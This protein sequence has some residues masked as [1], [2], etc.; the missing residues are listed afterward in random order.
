MENKNKDTQISIKGLENLGNTCYLNTTLQCLLF[1]P[2]FR[3]KVLNYTHYDMCKTP[4]LTQLHDVYTKLWI[5]RKTVIPRG[6]THTISQSFIGKMIDVKNPNDLH[7]FLSLFVDALIEEN[8]NIKDD[9]F[10][11]E[12]SNKIYKPL[13]QKIL[14]GRQ[15]S[16]IICSHCGYQTVNKEIFSS[17]MLSFSPSSLTNNTFNKE[18]G[19]TCTQE[20]DD[21]L[22]GSFREE[23]IEG[24]TC[25]NC[26]Q[27]RNEV[28]KIRLNKSPQVLML[29]IRRYDNNG[30][31]INTTLDIPYD[32]S[33]STCQPIH[34][35][36]EA[37]QKHYEKT[38]QYKICAIACHYGS[39]QNGHY[40]SLVHFE[41]TWY[42]IDDHN[43][44]HIYKL[45]SSSEY[46]VL[47]YE[48]N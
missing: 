38:A 33:L 21:L 11:L 8:K 15:E 30:R 28:R 42:K 3:K 39:L 35:F 31:R 41:N 45:P 44:Q 5:E 24:R 13:F 9:S 12:T 40:Y 10:T 26:H 4:L 6:L 16:S 47:F 46:Y 1:C 23:L 48:K 34:S 32:L 20:L 22:K 37:N 19:R 14:Q 27:T 18:V 29:M 2:S 25:D 36:C 7:E 17:L 43:V